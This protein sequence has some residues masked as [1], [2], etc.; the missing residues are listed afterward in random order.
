MV[1]QLGS[2][3]LALTL[4]RAHAA[5]GEQFCQPP[6]A[7]AVRRPCEI[8]RAI[9]EDDSCADDEAQ[10]HVFRRD[11]RAHHA[12]KTVEVADADACV[13]EHGSLRNHLGRMRRAFEQCEIGAS[14]DF[15]EC[16]GHAR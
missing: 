4:W 16:G 6:I 3:D 2:A 13:T 12:G 1:D 14:A 9:V 11:M 8:R 5:E 7:H 10:L 15:R